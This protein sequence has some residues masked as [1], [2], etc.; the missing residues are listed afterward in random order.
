[1]AR[2]IVIDYAPRQVFRP[3][4]NRAKRWAVI[5]AHRRAGKTVACVNE[6]IKR[7]IAEGKPNARYA[8]IA[9][10]YSQ[11]K[12]VAWDYL[13]YYA[14]PLLSEPPRESDLAVHL[15]TGGRIRLYGADN[16][17][18]LRG[19]YFDGVILDEYADMK[20]SVWS[21]VVR[22]T[23][24]DRKGWAVFIGTPKGKNAFW[25]VWDNAGRDDEWS[26]LMLKASET[27][28][29]DEAELRSARKSMTEDQYNQEYECSFEAA[30]H[31]A[32]YGKWMREALEQGRIGRVA[33]VP[34]MPVHTAWDLGFD[35]STAIWFYQLAI[36]EIRVIDYYENSGNGI[37]HY[38]EQVRGLKLLR[39][40]QDQIVFTDGKPSWTSEALEGAE[41]RQKY[42]YE[43]HWMPHD[44][45]NE[46]LAA[47]GRS[48]VNQAWDAGIE[49]SV[50][51]S[52]SQQNSIEATRMTLPR[53]WFDEDRCKD[54]IEALRQ[55]QF[56][57]DDDKKTFKSKPRH[58]WAS[59]G[60]DAFEIIGQTWR[61]P[62]NLKEREKPRWLDQARSDELF[63]LEG[64]FKV[65]SFERER[66]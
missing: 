56:E 26:R 31:G 22:P 54:G 1:M 4:H 33:H 3:F 5:V 64:K 59:H 38:L 53:C 11:A 29:L 44:A 24:S 39:D 32:V 15:I 30:I 46:L 13:K 20:P 41:H 42:R 35:D 17:N 28:I 63:D 48:I 14:H 6:L 9:P 8:Y 40:R 60:A 47:G 2:R 18:I 50:I 37:H 23:L 7:A 10:F 16:P 25:Q 62:D 57:W 49:G 21:E 19:L 27:Q 55:Y 65:H 34:G 58:D 51:P 52:T 43:R 66:F 45:A 61:E 36:G 12:G